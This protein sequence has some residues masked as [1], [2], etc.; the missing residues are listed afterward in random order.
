MSLDDRI[1]LSRL[2]AERQP[3]ICVGDFIEYHVYFKY[4]LVEGM[5]PKCAGELLE[6]LFDESENVVG[7]K[8]RVLAEHG[9]KYGKWTLIE[10]KEEAQKFN[11]EIPPK[12]KVHKSLESFREKN[13]CA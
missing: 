2:I 7:F 11:L 4:K 10:P 5:V 1:A 8:L 13:P 12:W 6:F 9:F 3:P